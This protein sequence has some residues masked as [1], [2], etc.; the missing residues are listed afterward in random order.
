MSG[1]TLKPLQIQLK[2]GISMTTIEVNFQAETL[3]AINKEFR[4][5]KNIYGTYDPIELKE[6]PE[7]LTVYLFLK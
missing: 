3:N 6:L 7:S 1:I 4:I 5:Q 2:G